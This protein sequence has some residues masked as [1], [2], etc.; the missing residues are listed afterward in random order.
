MIYSMEKLKF[1]WRQQQFKLKTFFGIPKDMP[2]DYIFDLLFDRLALMKQ[3]PEA[4][5]EISQRIVQGITTKR[6]YWVE[7]VLSSLIATLGL[8][9][10][11][12]AVIIGAMLI[13]P[14]LR[15]IQGLGYAVAVG[16]PQLFWRAFWLLVFSV[17]VSVGVPILVLLVLPAMEPNSEILSRTQPNL[18]DLLIAIFSA[19]IA[20]LAY[21]YR[22]LYESV[23]GVAMATALMPPLAVVGIQLYWGNMALAFGAMTLFFT[24]LV[25]ILAVGAAIFIMYGFNPHRD[26]TKS[27]M[28]QIGFLLL[29][30][31][32]LWW[33]LSSNLK[34]IRVQ[35]QHLTQA[36]Q[37]L[38]KNL[39]QQIPSAKVRNLTLREEEDATVVSGTLYVAENINL[40]RAQFNGLEAALN[41]Q[42]ERNVYLELNLV[43]TVS[44]DHDD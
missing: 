24:N 23:A 43:R 33:T 4:K 10:N 36:E 16:R 41:K 35:R 32:V 19:F 17:L 3:A 29:M 25:A 12:V 31:L 15:P 27:S 39:T 6:L 22:R 9:Q 14:L 40:S 7:V 13:A 5:A 38:D 11:S 34:Q 37:V 28:K 8:L 1:W 20:I 26:Q 18:L 30:M 42:L 2:W 44:F 21:A